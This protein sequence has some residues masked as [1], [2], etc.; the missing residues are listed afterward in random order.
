MS[1]T[2]SRANPVAKRVTEFAKRD[3]RKT[4]VVRQNYNNDIDDIASDYY[5]P[6]DALYIIDG[7]ESIQYAEE[8]PIVKY[9]C[10][11][12]ASIHREGEACL[13]SFVKSITVSI[14]RH[15]RKVG[16][17]GQVHCKKTTEDVVVYYTDNVGINHAIVQHELYSI[18]LQKPNLVISPE[19]VLIFYTENDIIATVGCNNGCHVLSGTGHAVDVEMKTVENIE[20]CD[21]YCKVLLVDYEKNEHEVGL[22]FELDATARQ[23]IKPKILLDF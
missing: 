21:N 22:M 9:R 20:V 1:E 19:G 23:L 13:N 12:N 3:M 6:N 5:Y 4:I 15:G 17:S 10:D 14:A 11:E 18:L 7:F 2:E 8:Y 16:F